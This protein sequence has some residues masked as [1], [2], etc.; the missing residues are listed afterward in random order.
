MAVFG[1]SFYFRLHFQISR[2]LITPRD[3]RAG[4]LTPR[5]K[6]LHRQTGAISQT[7]YRTPIYII[8]LCV[9]LCIN[10][11]SDFP[12]GCGGNVKSP[13]LRINSKRFSIY[14]CIYTIY[15]VEIYSEGRE[16]AFRMSLSIHTIYVIHR[17][18]VCMCE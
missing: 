13:P 16:N 12:G 5:D 1:N 6:P 17:Y 14:T 2:R 3:K 11:C 7:P 10:S 18:V 4:P 8:Y 15:N 9:S